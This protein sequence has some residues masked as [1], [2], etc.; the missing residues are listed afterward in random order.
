MKMGSNL[1]QNG[2][3]SKS[4]TEMQWQ[5][6]FDSLSDLVAVIDKYHR[7]IKV[8]KAMADTL[9]VSPEELIGKNCFSI[10]HGTENPP[11]LCPHTKLLK[12]GMCHKVEFPIKLLNGDYSVSVNP[13]LDS[14][15]ELTGSVHVVHNITENRKLSKLNNYL[16]SLVE[17]SDD[18]IFGK[19]LEGN[20][21]SWNK[22]A[23]NMFGY[24]RDEILGKSVSKIV[25]PD[26]MDDYNQIMV[27]IREGKSIKHHDTVRMK[28]NG[29]IIDVS[30]HISPMYDLSGTI[31]GS[32]TIAHNII[33]RKL[34]EKNL[35]ENEEKYH[36]VFNN[37]NDM[38][39]LNYME[40]DGF[41]GKFID[42]N[43]IGVERYGYTY[44]EFLNMTPRDL[45][46]PEDREKMPRNAKNLAKSSYAEF[47][48]LHVAKNGRKIPVEINNHI[49]K[50]NGKNVAIAIVRDITQRKKTERALVVS[51]NRYRFLFENMLEGFMLSKM[52][53]NQDNQPVDWVHIDVNNSYKKITGLKDTL[54]KNITDIIPNLKETNPELYKIF[55][56]VA[57]NGGNETFETYIKF[58]DKWL[59]ISVFSP[60]KNY[61]VAVFEDIT[62]RKNYELALVQSEEKFREVFNNAND[63]MFL[64]RLVGRDPGNFI[65]VNDEASRSLGYS[66]E[67]LVKMSPND[68]DSYNTLSAIPSVIETV[69]KE[70]GV[71]FESEQITK[72]GRLLP[73]EINSHIFNIRGEKYLLSIARDV[74]ERK[75]AEKA[76]KK[77]EIK[78]RTIFENIQDV[79]YQTDADGII[80]TISPSIERY[81]GYKP[82][83]L[84]GKPVVNLYVNPEKRKDLLKN[85]RE[86]GEVVDYELEFLNKD[87][88]L[89]Y[90]SI[91]AHQLKDSSQKPV[92]IEGT[93]RDISE[94]KLMEMEIK[95]SL[96]E[97]EMLLKEIHHRVKN[98]LMIIS[99]LLSL[100]SSYIEDKASKNIFIESQNRARSMALIHE[101]LYQSTDLKRINFGDY[102]RILTKEL[103]Y[104]YSVGSGRI[105]LKYNIEDIYLDINT[106]IPLGLIANELITNSLKY[107]FPDGDDGY[108][109]IEFKKKG[110]EYRFIIK[111][112]GTGLPDGLDY[113]NTDSLGLQLVNNLTEQIDGVIELNQ[114]NGTEFRIIFKEME[115]K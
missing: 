109:N 39:S 36:E 92:G 70:G 57:L 103:F 51:E 66:K 9:G 108:V 7:I 58:F 77:S 99:S 63:A 44:Q 89:I 31:N 22:G 105:D 78:Y 15:G 16:A 49:F 84:I 2:V 110:Q 4:D 96:D 41:P 67:E 5:Q 25:P 83:E 40:D 86:T 101:K 76:L 61:F 8:N 56:R 95:K 18:A 102:I 81:S 33:E 62:K 55:G 21:I 65:E 112:N 80:T 24:S 93:L 69:L 11:E 88:N 64:H 3:E 97:K 74:S 106:A 6:I 91:N 52:V 98:N 104:T 111:D 46:A 113:K 28:K 75:K 32:S 60:E 50:L 34:M 48:I 114:D 72:D 12:D 82:E 100:Q 10:M 53:F 71:T 42:V 47:E 30:L 94:R 107:A 17:S 54:G 79:F 35:H 13:I 85:I 23:E 37:A 19:D 68:I 14:N 26:Q 1:L 38:I 45:V 59:N 87:K 43:Q 29:E 73:V 115:M 27:K 20:V 90:V